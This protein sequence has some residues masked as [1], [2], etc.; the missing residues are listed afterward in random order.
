MSFQT[1]IRDKLRR[2]FRNERYKANQSQPP[3]KRKCIA[4]A[5]CSAVGLPRYI[6]ETETAHESAAKATFLLRKEGGDHTPEEIKSLKGASFYRR[7]KLILAGAPVSEVLQEFPW[8]RC[9]SEVGICRFICFHYPHLRW[10]FLNMGIS[11]PFT[12]LAL[13][14]NCP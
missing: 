1:I 7:R 13:E 9:E 12:A 14:S 11:T 4:Q 10:M 8:L 6:P 5:K 3:K 2:K